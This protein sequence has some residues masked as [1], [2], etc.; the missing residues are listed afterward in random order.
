M[1]KDEKPPLILIVDD[2]PQN[3]QV[4]GS[5]LR[6][7][8]YQVAVATN[9]V[10]VINM[11]DNIDPDLILLDVMM[12]EMDGLEVCER[13]KCIP[14]KKGIPIVFLTAK[15]E[16]EDI[17]KGFELG[18]VDYVTKPFNATELLARVKTHIELKR[19]R[20]IILELLT[21]L[22][23]K[24]KILEELA[25][26]DS[27]TRI[28]NHRHIIERLALEVQAA[29]R[30]GSSL[31]IIMFDID[32]FKSINDTHGH[33]FGDE[34][35]VKVTL[36]IRNELRDIDIVGRYGGEEFLV[37]LRNTDQKGAIHAGNRIRKNIMDLKW[38][39]DNVFVTISGGIATLGD[40]DVTGLIKKADQ[41]L[42][43][44][45]DN[46]RNRLESG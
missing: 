1:H 35:L 12:P 26:T 29:K 38:D 17:V 5:I 44:A 33:Q 15:T 34:V 20:D 3:L 43:K 42:Y 23:E 31:S 45:K 21:A 30:H 9:G 28:Y 25:V 2:L 4:L 41:L 16:I 37:V 7:Q 18:A 39:V 8:N 36:T 40:E 14:E 19:N 32:H 27:L 11:I 6:K 22:E 24:N 46:G 13:L 10:Q